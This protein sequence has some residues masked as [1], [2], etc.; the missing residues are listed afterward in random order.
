[1]G[2]TP[3]VV[4]FTLM[5]KLPGGAPDIA[6][7]PQTAIFT[8]TDIASLA[9]GNPVNLTASGQTSGDGV[10]QGIYDG[11]GATATL[12]VSVH[13]TTTGTNGT[14]VDPAAPPAL[15][16]ATAPDPITTIAPLLYPYDKT[17][18]PLGLTSPLVM[19]NAPKSGDVYRLHY[20]EKDFVCDDYE[21]VTA[22][23]QMRIEQKCWDWLTSSNTGD[24]ITVTLSRWDATT[25]TAYVSATESWT[26][27]H[28]SMQGAI[29][30][31]TT[32]ST[33]DAYLAKLAVGAGAQAQPLTV[34]GQKVCMACH[35]VSADGTTLVAA[36][37]D[38]GMPAFPG[39]T[40]SGTPGYCTTHN[41]QESP[42]ASDDRAWVSFDVQPNSSALTMRKLSNLF[43]G[44]LAVNPDGKYTVFGDVQLYLADTT[45]G[46]PITGTG[47]DTYVPT[48]PNVGLMM[49]AFSPDGN[50]LVA[51]EGPPDPSGSPSFITLAGPTGDLLQFDFNESTHMFSNPKHFAVES[52]S[53]F[54]VGQTAIAYPTF[55]PDANWIAFH[56]GD[57]PTA[58]EGNCDTAETSLGANLHAEHGRRHARSPSSAQRHADGSR[59]PAEPQLRAHVRPHGARWLL[60]GRPLQRAGLGQPD[61]R[62][63]R[64]DARERQQASLGV[65][66]RRDAG[67]HRPEPPALLPGGAGPDAPEH[68]R[69][70]GE[71]AL[72][73]HGPELV[74]RGV[75]VLLGVLQCADVRGHREHD[76]DVHPARRRVRAYRCRGIS[77]R[78]L[79]TRW[80]R[81]LDPRV[82]RRASG[83][84]PQQHLPD[85]DEPVGTT[86]RASRGWPRRSLRP[87]GRSS[88]PRL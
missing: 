29:Y 20:E 10:L 33:T 51:V 54:P 47:L 48:A 49:P 61:R 37:G 74:Q 8:R 26:L 53:G 67:H 70:L 68:A 41:C 88:E 84:V 4:P 40:T 38:I 83:A 5:A 62:R 46:T 78:R 24:P 22:P 16:G 30:Y 60:L 85:P 32:A 86:S 52:T 3:L 12:H 59:H 11:A 64:Q 82:L 44:N 65:R 80:R 34:N 79:V 13:L 1:M 18:F 35:A 55:S 9:I 69:I 50:H 58:C 27:A 14:S 81:A 36:A 42:I 39:E 7:A 45:A 2:N 15:D 76:A 87:R 28:A 72:H 25:M 66:H 19:W 6:V 75:P 57:T 77:G 23:A 43:A 71:R 21:V 31:W 17:V 56:V 73:R 63:R